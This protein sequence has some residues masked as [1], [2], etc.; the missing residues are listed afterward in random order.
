MPA[1]THLLSRL[2][3]KLRRCFGRCRRQFELAE[4]HFYAA[5]AQAARCDT[6]SA[7]ERLRHLEALAAHHRQIAIWAENCPETFANRAALVGAEIA[8][9]EGRELD[10]MRLYEEAIRLGA[11]ARLHPERGAWPT[12]CAARFYAARGFETIAQAYLR[13]A[14][15]LLSA[16][17]RRGQGAAARATAPASARGIGSAAAHRHHSARPSSNWTSAPWSR[18]RRRCRARSNSA[19]SSK[20]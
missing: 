15:S 10:A 9:L 20:P 12:S 19:S 6:A 14:R 11:R 3:R 2:H 5:L 4:Y 16:L 13:N 18:L 8:R 1:T 17:G 7:E